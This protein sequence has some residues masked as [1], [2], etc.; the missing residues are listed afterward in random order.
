MRFLCPRRG[1][2][3][4]GLCFS[5]IYH[6]FYMGLFN[7]RAFRGRMGPKP[8]QKDNNTPKC[9]QQRPPDDP[10]Q[11]TKENKKHFNFLFGDSGGQQDL[12]EWTCD[13]YFQR[14][15]AFGPSDTTLA[16]TW[17]PGLAQTA[18]PFET[19]VEIHKTSFSAISEKIEP[20]RC[21]LRPKPEDFN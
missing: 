13:Q 19:G 5:F 9:L 17:S 10:S 8:F 4:F 6:V 2:S 3:K 7:N 12:V 11:K 14:T 16:P 15:R 1:H 18:I 21:R 20:A